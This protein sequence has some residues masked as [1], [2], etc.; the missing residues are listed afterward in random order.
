MENLVPLAK[1]IYWTTHNARTLLFEGKCLQVDRK[2][3]S[4]L[5]KCALILKLIAEKNGE[6]ANQSTSESRPNDQPTGT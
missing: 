5:T 2:L 4:V 6:L 3:Q 1:E